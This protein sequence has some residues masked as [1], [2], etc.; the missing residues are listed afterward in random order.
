MP[1]DQSGPPQANRSLGDIMQDIRRR[2]DEILAQQEREEPST[3][4]DEAEQ[5]PGQVEHLLESDTD[6]G[7]QALG[8]AGEEERQKLED[9]NIVDEDMEGEAEA[10]QRGMEDDDVEEGDSRPAPRPADTSIKPEHTDNSATE[11]AL[12]P[13]SY[14]HL[15]LPTKRI[16]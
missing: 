6:E 5:A 7:L 14:T 4:P 16:V 11:K 9:L 3:N 15:T 12:T 13:V 8:A 10:D 1:S 2:R